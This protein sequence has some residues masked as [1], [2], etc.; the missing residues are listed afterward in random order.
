MYYQRPL[1]IRVIESFCRHWRIF[2]ATSVTII[3]LLFAYIVTRPK[4]YVTQFTVILNTQTLINPVSNQSEVI[5]WNAVSQNVGHFQTLVQTKEFIQDA[6]SPLNDPTSS[7]PHLEKHIDFDNDAQ[8]ASVQRGVSIAPNGSDAFTVGLIYGDSTDSEL[9]LNALISKFMERTAQ[10]KSASYTEQVAFD[11]GQVDSFTALEADASARLT[12]FSTQHIGRLPSEQDSLMQDLANQKQRLRDLQVELASDQSRASLL[13]QE[14]SQIPKQIVSNTTSQTSPLDTQ[15][16]ALSLKLDTDIANGFKP[17]HPEL[18]NL[19]RQIDTL[20]KIKVQR[21]T[22]GETSGITSEDTQP[23]PAYQAAKYQLDNARI[24]I[25]GEQTKVTDLAQQ[26]T[27]Q[28]SGVAK[29]PEEARIYSTLLGEYQFDHEQLA[30]MLNS[31]Q[32]AKDNEEISLKEQQSNYTPLET[33]QPELSTS[34]SKTLILFAGGLVL[35]LIVSSA[36]VIL[37]EAMD[38]SFR[39]A[40]DLQRTLGVP[41]LAMLPESADLHIADSRNL[42]TGSG[43]MKRLG[44]GQPSQLPSPDDEPKAGDDSRAA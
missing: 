36:L 20:R 23:N 14:L 24:D 28:T 22:S 25:T 10:E 32:D 39:D 41:V 17:D 19:E 4:N 16:N 35:A 40:Y 15:I 9:I 7:G 13:A 44:I 3:L 11:K 12:A 6:L 27:Q 38:R 21:S 2:L 26:I 8:L 37:A 34:K 18:R 33:M 1:F 30:K 43:G 5:D 42:L 31:L 29:V